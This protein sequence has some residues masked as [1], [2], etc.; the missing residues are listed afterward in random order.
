MGVKDLSKSK[1]EAC[2]QCGLEISVSEFVLFHTGYDIDE[3]RRLKTAKDRKEHC[4]LYH[5]KLR[6]M[7]SEGT[8]DYGSA[9][10]KSK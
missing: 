9:F 8:Y 2:D 3:G 4:D 1:S 10:K 5:T 7:Q 6:K